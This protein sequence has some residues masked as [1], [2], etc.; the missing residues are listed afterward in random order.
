MVSAPPLQVSLRDIELQQRIQGGLYPPS[1]ADPLQGPAERAFR[2]AIKESYQGRVPLPADLRKRFTDDWVGKWELPEKTS[3]Y[4]AGVNKAAGFAR[5]VYFY[6]L[7]YRVLQPFRPYTLQLDEGQV[8]GENALVWWDKYRSEPVPML[9]DG[10]LRRPRKTLLPN[11]GVLAQWLAARQGLDSSVDLGI[12]HLPWVSGEFWTT[13]RV[14]G[15]LAR[16]WINAIVNQAA[17]PA[18]A[19]RPGDE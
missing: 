4:W 15:P 8:T 3:A 17:N 14:D 19:P 5:R 2:W 11:Y 9:I 18:A 13:K 7:K 10:L 16:I 6:L 1:K 12:A